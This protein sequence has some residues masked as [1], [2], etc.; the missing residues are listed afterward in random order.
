MPIEIEELKREISDHC[1]FKEL[2]LL[3]EN[4]D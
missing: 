3:Q 4:M 1:G 2:M